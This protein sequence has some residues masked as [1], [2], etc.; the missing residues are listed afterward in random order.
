MHARE[1]ALESKLFGEDLNKAFPVVEPDCSDSGTFDNVLEFMLMSGRT[2]QEAV[3]MMVPE[4]WQNHVLMNKHKRAF[5]EY[6]SCLMEPWDGPASIAF[7]DGQYIGAVLDRNGLR[8]SRYYVTQDDLVIMASEVGVVPVEPE[9]VLRK[10]RLQPGRMFLV[11]F[12][13][14]RIIADDELKQNWS[15]ERPYQ[16]WLDR[17]SMRLHKL[18]VKEDVPPPHGLDNDTL[19]VRQQ[20]F[21]YTVETM[22]MMLRPLVREKRDPL[23]SMGN[24]A[25]LACL[26]EKP[27]LVYDYF[28]QL[29]AQVTNPAVDSIRE[30]IILSLECYIGPEGNLLEPRERNA[31]RLRIVHPILTNEEL[32]RIRHIDKTNRG[33]ATGYR[34]KVLDATFP[35][36]SGTAGLEPALRRL[37]KEAEDAVDEGYAL[38][39][40]SDRAQNYERVAVPALLTCGAVHQHLLRTTKRTRVGLILET[41]EAREVHH[42]CLLVGYGADA[43]NPY[44]AYESLWAGRPRCAPSCPNLRQRDRAPL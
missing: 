8:P 7:T 43:I 2:L 23:G 39:L 19:L 17:H 29:F 41:G 34:T 36:S 21:G 25:A 42:H 9:R 18:I 14:G 22:R 4:A 37:A 32:H 30:S 5:Y 6:H 3:M 1:G 24:D 38:V 15:R 13:A 20:A 35:R 10:G 40:L 28:K 11:D 27:R 16:E 33:K 12:E 26:S 31:R 44:L